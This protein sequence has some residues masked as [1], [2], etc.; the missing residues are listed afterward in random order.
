M[1]V[2]NAFQAANNKTCRYSF[3]PTLVKKFDA[4][5]RTAALTSRIPV[6]VLLNVA[7]HTLDLILKLPAG[8]LEGVVEGEIEVGIALIALRG[9]ADIDL[10]PFRQGKPHGDL[11]KTPG[12]MVVA[13][14]FEGDASGGDAAE[15]FLELADM[16]GDGG[17]QVGAG[18]H[19]LKVDLNRGFHDFFLPG[20]LRT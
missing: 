9:A 20:F 16:L 4:S 5:P 17:A 10:A 11:V 14:R 3:V 1:C 8:A 12:T 13:W 2:K 15:P 7:A 6:G 19:A 18:L